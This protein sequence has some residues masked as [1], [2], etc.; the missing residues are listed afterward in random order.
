MKFKLGRFAD[1]QSFADYP[2]KQVLLKISQYSQESICVAVSIS[3]SCRPSGLQVNDILQHQKRQ[4]RINSSNHRNIPNIQPGDTVIIKNQ[5]RQ[6]KSHPYF[7]PEN[8]KV[9]SYTGQHGLKLENTTNNH[10]VIRHSDD[11]KLVYNPTTNAP[12]EVKAPVNYY[13]W[14]PPLTVSESNIQL[15]RHPQSAAEILKNKPPQAAAPT[16]HEPILPSLIAHTVSS[17]QPH[18]RIQG[19]ELLD[20]PLPSTSTTESITTQTQQGCVP[21]HTQAVSQYTSVHPTLHLP[22]TET[23]IPEIST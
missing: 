15:T 18:S 21:E 22:Q 12:V 3:Y 7:G 20:N 10:T 1:F 11:V 19:T 23:S 16:S 8:Y 14:I 13:Y 17:H 9:I 2:S 6:Q 4:E 5:Q